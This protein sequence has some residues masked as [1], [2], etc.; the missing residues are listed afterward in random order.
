[1]VY[2]SAAS[3]PVATAGTLLLTIERN[4][5]RPDGQHDGRSVLSGYGL[6]L[7]QIRG[8]DWLRVGSD[9]PC[10]SEMS[11][12]RSAG[13]R[14]LDARTAVII[15]C[16]KS[17]LVAVRRNVRPAQAVQAVQGVQAVQAVRYVCL[18]GLVTTLRRRCYENPGRLWVCL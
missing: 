10:A 8:A 18:N 2:S 1:M 12:N 9:G 3:C 15:K 6:P 7:W 11:D 5:R 14:L 16:F 13:A 17:R 4:D